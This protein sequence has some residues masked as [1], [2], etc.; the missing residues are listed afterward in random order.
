[1]SEARRKYIEAN[2]N[3]IKF[4]VMLQSETETLYFPSIASAARYLGVTT[5]TMYLRIRRGKPS[6]RV[7]YTIT[8]IS[9]EFYN[10]VKDV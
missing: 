2:P 10:S 9:V 5:D 1:M 3:P 8:K 4:P 6:K 7:P